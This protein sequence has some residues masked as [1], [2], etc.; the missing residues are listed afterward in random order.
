MREVELAL[1]DVEMA[2][3]Q[4]E[5]AIRLMCYCELGH[6]DT[7]GFDTDIVILLE[8]E[9]IGFKNGSFATKDS[10][11]TVSQIQVGVAFGVSAITLDAAYD[12]AGKRRAPEYRDPR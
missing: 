4:W 5:F 12:T 9:N 10:V 8:N 11:V 2:F 1:A 6:I 3:Q 7:D